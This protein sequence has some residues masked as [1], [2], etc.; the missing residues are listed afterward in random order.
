MI[1]CSHCN[2]QNLPEEIYCAAC[3]SALQEGSSQAVLTLLPA[4]TILAG[5]YVIETSESF[6]FENRYRA[7]RVGDAHAR[8]LLRERPLEDAAVLQTLAEQVTGLSHP[9]LVIPEHFF[10]CAGRAYLATPDIAGT[11]LS[12]RVGLTTEREALS[13]GIQLCQIMNALHRNGFLCVELPPDG[14]LL[15]KDGRIRLTHLESLSRKTEA[16]AL[17]SVTD[18][19]AAPEVY[20]EGVVGESVDVFA[21]GALLFSLVIGKRLPVEGW[22]VQPAPPLFYPEKAVSPDFERVLRR[23]LSADPQARYDNVEQLKAAFLAL[24]RFSR[25]RSAWLTDVGQVRDHNEDAVLVQEYGRGTI[26]GKAFAGLYIVSDGMGGAEAGEVASTLT[27]Q[28]IAQY[29]DT[30]LRDSLTLEANA[31]EVCLREAVEAA[32]TAIQ[33]YAQ[34]HPESAGLGATVVAALVQEQQLTLAWVGDSR[35]Y[36]WEQGELRQLS[37]DHSLVARLMEIGQLS[38]EDART[39]EHRNVLLR[40]LGNKAQVP[41]E[42][43]SLPLRRGARLLLCSDGLTGHVEDD[44]IK[45]VLSRHRDPFD[46]AVEL[47]AAANVDGGS[48]NISVVVTFHE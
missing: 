27:I 37:R 12:T 38:P 10:A 33:E 46:A 23:A 18:G 5:D 48:D 32:N 39:H 4:G 2:Q 8:V 16:L 44:V 47:V 6:D 31:C 30:A 24:N 29:V 19:Y 41:V 36:V 21:I 28:T 3:G 9:A 22:A 42:V 13:W 35:G 25:V 34:S 1:C 7:I 20:R 43:V 26:A 11:R 14:V 17:R 15:D 40:S 45:D